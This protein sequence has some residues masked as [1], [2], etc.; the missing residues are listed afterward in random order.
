MTDEAK[1]AT[2]YRRRAEELRAEAATATR[3]EIKR[4]LI[5]IA[6]NYVQMAKFIEDQENP[7]K[8]QNSNSEKWLTDLTVV[9]AMMEAAD[10]SS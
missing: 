4:S 10:I 6:D 1:Q 7:P 2:G 9:K 5:S 3:P 8:V